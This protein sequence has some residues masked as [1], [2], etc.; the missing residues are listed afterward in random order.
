LPMGDPGPTR[1]SMAFRAG[2]SMGSARAYALLA[3]F[4]RK[5]GNFS[6]SNEPW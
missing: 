3:S 5:C 6:L 4:S 2:V 1:V